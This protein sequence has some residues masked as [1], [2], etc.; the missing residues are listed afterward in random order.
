MRWC[1]IFGILCIFCNC[2]RNHIEQL[3]VEKIVF[4]ETINLTSKVLNDSCLFT[5]VRNMEVLD[6][7]LIFMDGRSSDYFFHLYNTDGKWL[8]DFAKKG[9]APGELIAAGDFYLDKERG[10][11]Q[12]Y[13]SSK[14]E[15]VE[16]F[17]GALLNNEKE[18]FRSY[19]IY[20]GDYPL[21]CIKY[22]ADRFLCVEMKDRC[23]FSLWEDKKLNS[24]YFH[25]PEIEDT[26]NKTLTRAML[27]YSGKISFT[28]DFKRFVCGSY[29][30]AILETFYI[31]NGNL[32]RDTINR[33]FYPRCATYRVDRMNK[34]NFDIS[35]DETTRI[36]FEDIV[37]TKQGVYTLL[38]GIMGSELRKRDVKQPYTTNISVF[39]WECNPVLLVHTDRMLQAICVD[40]NTRII[41][42]LAWNKGEHAI[43]K[44]KY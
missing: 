42:G 13:H 16:Y 23:R 34:D 35:W 26:G 20:T 1:I 41:Y 19:P 9:R 7:L 14:K 12:V 44:M 5:R 29:I 38:N 4:P 32:V 8:K 2:K 39:D 25:Y 18:Y 15:V 30:G 37:A 22:D 11:V 43:V 6:T 24:V 40:E 33:I 17:L 36:G 21:R 3:Y 28:P 31:E 10:C 27:N